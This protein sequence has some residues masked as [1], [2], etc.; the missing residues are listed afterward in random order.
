MVATRRITTAAVIAGCLVAMARLAVA[1]PALPADVKAVVER[2]DYVQRVERAVAIAEADRA[3]AA[4]PDSQTRVD[5]DL[6]RIARLLPAYERII[7]AG[8]A[9]NVDNRPL[10]DLLNSARSADAGPKRR[11]LVGEIARRL[12]TVADGFETPG[13]IAGDRATLRRVLDQSVA[14]RPDLITQLSARLATWLR[15]AL[16]KRFNLS[17]T[18]DGRAI[19]RPPQ[20]LLIVASAVIILLTSA[21]MLRLILR[22]VHVV[23]VPSQGVATARLNDLPEEDPREEALAMAREGDRR[24]AVR[25]LFKS[26]QFRLDAIRLVRYRRA[27]TNSEYLDTVRERAGD[28]EPSVRSMIGTFERTLYGLKDC[29]ESEFERYDSDY[30]KAVEEAEKS[31]G[32]P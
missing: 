6:A 10:V 4:G 20:W 18:I 16:G 26:L 15:Q 11:R 19:P 5:L 24:E 7:F 32:R 13:S 1:A 23:S 8:H 12:Q 27:Q 29:G 9:I 31:E 2:G 28:I 14:T 22:R 17:P 30:R 25:L 3:V 21:L